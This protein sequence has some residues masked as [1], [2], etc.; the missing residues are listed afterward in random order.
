MIGQVNAEADEAAIFH[1][2]AFDDAGEQG[3]VNISG[4]DEDADFF[5]GERGVA[6]QDCGGGDGSCAFGER[7]LFFEEQQDGVGD[8]FFVYGDDFVHVFA[9]ERQGEHACGADGDAVGDGF[10][11]GQRDD[12][13]LF[14]RC[15][16]GR[17]LRGLHADH[18]YF[19]IYFFHG[20]GYSGDQ[21]A[22]ADGNHYGVQIGDLLEHLDAQR[23]LAGDDGF[24]VEGMDE[25]EGLFGAE[26]EGF[27]A[28]FV[29][30]RAE[31][32][33]F[34][35]V[36]ARGG[37]FYERSGERHHDLRR[38][39][40][41]GGVVGDG[42]RVIAGGGGDDAATALVRS[43]Q[44]NFIQRAAFLEGAGH[45]QIFEFE[46]EGVSGE[47]GKSFGAHEGR[48]VDGIANAFGGLLNCFQRDG[49]GGRPFALFGAG[50][51][52]VVP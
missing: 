36:A 24:V 18:F 33:Y 49:A 45:L 46:E 25:S 43:E 30:I 48:D 6:V 3:D 10:F 2:A 47:L 42:L 20:A 13:I 39:A 12:G 44:E 11:G 21:S 27:L 31:E 7:F 5:S 35:A 40:A 23:A 37:D 41:F 38:D 51:H 16:H 8:F 4:G 50:I 26:A 52:F 15:F 14:D 9:D 17:Q 28:G 29:V 1:Q 22:A 19:W 32:D 34:G